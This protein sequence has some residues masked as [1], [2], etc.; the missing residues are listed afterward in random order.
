MR[1]PRRSTVAIALFSAITLSFAAL[2][3]YGQLLPAM[4]PSPYDGIPPCEGVTLTV[5]DAPIRKHPESITISMQNH[6][7]LLAVYGLTFSLERWRHGAWQ[8]L[9]MIE[10]HYFTM[11]AILLEPHAQGEE[12]LAI[13]FFYAS[14]PPGRYRIVKPLTLGDETTYA[15]G[16]FT[17]R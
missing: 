13:S 16:A 9:Q 15:A 2:G 5:Q 10:G 7:D 11:P 6:T 12:T 4:G 8:A 14:V 3:L 17:V 1:L